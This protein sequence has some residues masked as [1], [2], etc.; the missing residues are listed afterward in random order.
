MS[1]AVTTVLRGHLKIARVD[2]WVKNVCVLPGV[3]AAVGLDPEADLERLVFRFF[4]GMASVC[5]IAS[6]NYVINEVM[7]APHDRHHPT[8]RARPVPSG[9]VSVP[10]AYLQWLVLMVV[11]LAVAW[12][13]SRALA[14]VLAAFWVMGG[15]YNLP[16]I[17]SKELPYLDV[18]SEA[19]NNP[20]RLLAG[21]FIATNATVPPGSLLL[22]YWM[23]GAYFMAMKR[24]AEYRDLRTGDIAAAAMY[25]RSFAFYNEQ[26]LLVS[27]MF[28]ASAAMLFF[29]AFV[30]RYRLEL[31]GSFPLVALVMATSLALAFR[32]CSVVQQPEKL[33]REPSLMIAVAAC[34][35]VIVILLFVDIPILYTV[36]APTVPVSIR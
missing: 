18:L 29:G 21:W 1:R 15:I 6:S 8:K 31:I 24:F 19:I 36:F 10:F 13:M 25:R 30:M 17:R 27:M 3:V 35:A 23:V 2:Q 14:V 9:E 28:Y 12:T 20:L 16:P 34:A 5:L 11:G 32:P 4:I 7:D 33:Y 26:R 22:S